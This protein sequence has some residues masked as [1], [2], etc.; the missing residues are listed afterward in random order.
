MEVRR[1][2]G[3]HHYVVRCS[4]RGD[5]ARSAAPGHDH[6]V[7]R[8]PALEDLVPANESAPLRRQEGVHLLDEP[9]LQL[10]FVLKAELFDARL[11][12][13]ARLPLR[14]DRFISADVDVLA[15]K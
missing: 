14:L 11:R 2:P 12:A 10:V 1:L 6:G 8:E 15:W 7:V 13:W 9:T 3:G 5:A 4:R